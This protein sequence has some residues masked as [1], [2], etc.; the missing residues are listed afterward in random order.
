MTPPVEGAPPVV[1]EPRVPRLPYPAKPRARVLIDGVAFDPMT[2]DETSTYVHDSLD[3]GRGGQIITPNVDVLRLL[4]KPEYAIA[5]RANLVVADGMPVV[6]ASRL[7]GTPVPV[8]V[9]GASL[10]R[11][12]AR[13]A[14][15]RGRSLYLLGGP[16]AAAEQAALNLREAHPRLKIAGTACPD[17]GFQE[18]PQQWAAV[19]EDITASGADIVFLALGAPKQEL[20]GIRLLEVLPDAWFLGCG[21]SMAFLAGLLPRAPEW[22]QRCGL[23]WTYRLKKE[24]RRLW[25]RY[26]VHDIPYALAMLTRALWARLRRR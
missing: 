9:A 15:L 11:T 7:S 23:E 4:R 19:V 14:E 13:D 25:R 1:V 2:E 6:W 24:P 18:D 8:R 5:A 10:V 21:G 26:L 20:V 12:L 16:P 17:W 22:M 3:A